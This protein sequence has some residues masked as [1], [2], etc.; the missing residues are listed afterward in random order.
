[1]ITSTGFRSVN[2]RLDTFW[3]CMNTG[4]SLVLRLWMGMMV[5]IIISNKGQ[6]YTVVITKSWE[7]LLEFFARHEHL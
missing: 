6:L 5:G 1:M 2:R 4:S 7:C 3:V